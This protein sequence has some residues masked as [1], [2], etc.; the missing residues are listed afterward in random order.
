MSNSNSLD[1]FDKTLGNQKQPFDRQ[2]DVSRREEREYKEQHPF[3]ML[4]VILVIVCIAANF[5]PS[6]AF[7]RIVSG[8]K[9]LIDPASFQ[10]IDKVYI[11]F[12]DFFLSFYEGFNQAAG[13]M[14]M[15]LFVGGAFGVIKHIGLLEASIKVLAAK[16][17]NLHFLSM[18]LI[19][20]LSFGTLVSLTGMYEL[21]IVLV[22]LIVP[23]Y[24]R[25]GYDVVVGTAVVLVGACAGLGAGMTN[26]FFTAIAQNIAELPLYSGILFRLVTFLT[27]AS[28]GLVLTYLY[29]KRIKNHP[30]RSVVHGVPVKFEKVQN[31]DVRLSPALKRA[32]VVFLGMFALLIYGSIKL[33]F[34]FPQMSA[35]F[36]AMAIF[37]GL[38]YGAGPN[39]ICHMFAR[40][41]SDMM[42]ASMVIFVARSILV[43]M[44]KAK[45]VDTV[46]NYLADLIGGVSGQVGAVLILVVQTTINFLI[47]SGSGQ[48]TITMPIIV[49]LSDL[50]E[51]NRQIAVLASQLGD[52][53][54]NFI[55]PTNGALIAI[56]SVAGIPYTKW[57]K[58]F[59][60]IYLALFATAVTLLSIASAIDYGPF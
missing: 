60:P 45:V 28:V 50:M 4:S 43:V 56:L 36:I 44:E 5:I 19:L 59:G 32:A 13:L 54:S 39:R 27:L 3:L 52:G 11:N 8:G 30:S 12:T 23:L 15:V 35:V 46:I 41:M 17:Q 2:T 51:V 16:L 29:A 6:G 22:P 1:E 53:M 38:A 48:A 57:L 25:F 37:V 18:S 10:I 42:I 21:S 55:F 40:G 47:P 26:P 24:L 31:L 7:K 34:S 9:T 49:P 20:I 14:G 58:F 33:G